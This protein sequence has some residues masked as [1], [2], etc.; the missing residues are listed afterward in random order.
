MI[1]R[2]HE[3]NVNADDLQSA[4]GERWPDFQS[5]L[6]GVTFSG[7]PPYT[8]PLYR[9]W[10]WLGRNGFKVVSEHE[11]GRIVVEAAKK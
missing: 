10:G 1:V 3:G 11:M 8:I 2:T 7:K 4:L 5:T 9:V 6:N